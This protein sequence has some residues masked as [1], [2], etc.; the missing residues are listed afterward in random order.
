MYTGEH[1]DSRICPVCGDTLTPPSEDGC[2]I[3]WHGTERGLLVYDRTTGGVFVHPHCLDHFDCDTVRE[4]E[5]QY[6]D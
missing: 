4:F 3:C 6:I 2:A 5:K 1:V